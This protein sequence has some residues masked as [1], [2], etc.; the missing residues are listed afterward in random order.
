MSGVICAH[1]FCPDAEPDLL[2]KETDT[3]CRSFFYWHQAEII[4]HSPAEGMWDWPYFV[5]PKKDLKDR[6]VFTPQKPFPQLQRREDI[7]IYRYLLQKKHTE[8]AYYIQFKILLFLNSLHSRS[9]V[10]KTNLRPGI[11]TN[12]YKLKCRSLWCKNSTARVRFCLKQYLPVV[13]LK[14]EWNAIRG[15]HKGKRKAWTLKHP[16]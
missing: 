8:S 11:I 14:T 5:L 7:H 16:V 3:V 10:T 1:S 9:N 6:L 4:K 2:S 15:N 12:L 13:P